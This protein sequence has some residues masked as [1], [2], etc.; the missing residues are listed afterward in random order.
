[1]GQGSIRTQLVTGCQKQISTLKEQQSPGTIQPTP[2]AS[3]RLKTTLGPG[4]T[5]QQGMFSTWTPK[6][7]TGCP[8]S[9]LKSCWLPKKLQYGIAREDII[10]TERTMELSRS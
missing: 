3:M 4:Q 6:P 5:R 2:M 10:I 7:G 1:M 9:S 8:K